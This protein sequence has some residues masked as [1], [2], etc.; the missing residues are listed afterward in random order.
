VEGKIN[1]GVHHCTYLTRH[2]KTNSLSLE[3]PLAL[4]YMKLHDEQCLHFQTPSHAKAKARY[5][6]SICTIKRTPNE[7]FHDALS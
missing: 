5:L 1:V 3:D 6:T 2:Y 4:L 7:Y